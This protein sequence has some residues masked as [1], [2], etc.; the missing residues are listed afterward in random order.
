VNDKTFKGKITAQGTDIAVL[1][2]GSD[3]DYISLTDIARYKNAKFPSEVIQIGLSN[4]KRGA[5]LNC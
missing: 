5:H 2:S 1:S 4:L 3:D